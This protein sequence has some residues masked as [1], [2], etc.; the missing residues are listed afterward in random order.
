M[1]ALARW[2]GEGTDASFRTA[3]ER[4]L[5]P[6]WLPARRWF[7]SKSRAPA[8]VVFEA[9]FPCDASEPGEAVLAVVRVDFA[10]G[11]PE[12][13]QL[14]LALLTPDAAGDFPE[15]ARIAAVA[16]P[17]GERVLVDAGW[18]AGFRNALRD[19]LGGA[20]LE[21]PFGGILR[22]RPVPA[23]VE[24]FAAK[25]APASRPLGG[26]QS[27]TSFLGDDAFVKL[28]RRLEPG[29]H[30]EPEMLRFLREHTD[31]RGVPAFLSGLEWIRGGDES[32]TVALAQEP[33]FG[34][35]AWKDLLARLAP[36]FA[37]ADAAVPDDLAERAA[38]LGGRVGALHAA[39]GGPAAARH[40]DFAPEPVNAAD[41]EAVRDE[42]RAL[43]DRALGSLAARRDALSSHAATL[44]DT[45]RERRGALEALIDGAGRGAGADAGLALRTH[46]DLH[47][48]QVLVADGPDGA[49]DF[50]ILDFEG[51]PGRTLAAARAKQSP[52][53]DA[54]GMI[55][56][57]HYAA[58][59]AANDARAGAGGEGGP[60]PDPARAAAAADALGAAF[61]RGYLD[62]AAGGGFL[63]AEGDGAGAS[64]VR[65]AL[66]DVFVLEKAVYE[67]DYELNNRP[68]WAEIPLQGL[69]TLCHGSR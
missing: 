16:T 29:P 7:R 43:L 14:P 49:P 40:P 39:L 67:L 55:R 27:N 46:G 9:A 38:R 63:P 19:L 25:P 61:L 50:R 17:D 69:V 57:L 31:Y 48:G 2:I 11:D 26:E 12:R 54:A 64:G 37:S 32:F 8:A 30:P 28:Y 34:D 47:L 33:V 60:P 65:A 45:L 44:A 56:S 10:D 51:E 5:L 52:L 21:R 59:V 4:D 6:T 36:V 41:L 22:G 35:D 13:Y 66:L 20:R 53:R 18:H 1:N 68:D 58:H 62:A 24:V 15:A 23:G 42:T 3:L